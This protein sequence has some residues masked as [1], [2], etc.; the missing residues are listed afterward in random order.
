MIKAIIFDFGGVITPT[1]PWA[2]WNP[3]PEERTI[4]R[5]AIAEIAKLFTA[6]LRES[7]FTADDFA[8]EFKARTG[9]LKQEPQE[10]IIKSIC[11]P[12]KELLDLI[13][14]LSAK[15]KIYGLVNAPFGW[16]ELRRGILGL[17]KYFSRV[18]VSHEIDVRKPDP[19]IFH[20]LLENT[21]LAPEECFFVDDREENVLAAKQ[22]GMEGCVFDS[23]KNLK[24]YFRTI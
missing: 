6:E 8:R 11:V 5:N 16:S 14:E 24:G 20:Y 4:I 17:D 12:D 9:E 19:K 21:G 7:K 23:V 10:R 13:S 15:Y 1:E 2:G 18:F 3:S 22:L